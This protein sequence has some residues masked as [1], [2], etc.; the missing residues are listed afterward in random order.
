MQN[1]KKI[2]GV[3]L[4]YKSADHIKDLCKSL[5]QGVLD[6]VF[7]TNDNSEDNI[8]EIAKNLNIKCFS[9]E[10][11]GYGGNMK[12]GINKAL[13]LGADYIVEIHGDGQYDPSF[14]I[15]AIEK[16]QEN[17]QY[18]LIIGSRF[19]DFKQPLRD[20]MSLLRYSANIVLSLI[21]SIILGVRLSEFNTGARVYN[22]N[23]FEKIKIENTSN[24][25]LFSFEII[26]QI[27]NMNI[28]I[29]EVPARCYYNKDHS[30]I[31]IKHSF[32]YAIK[33]FGTL[34]YF[35]MSKIGFKTKLF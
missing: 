30:S 28:K 14:I 24:D 31:S 20:K 35:L 19:I 2:I 33:T 32:I 15:P 18:G 6:D 4:A 34:F 22:K 23:I 26:A 11:L 10:R 27:V 7:I 29:G 21:D 8:E 13:E 9:H 16:I 5:P 17:E 25:F 3:I 12:Y 1:N